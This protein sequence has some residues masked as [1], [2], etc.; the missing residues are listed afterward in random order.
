MVSGETKQE[1][2][3]SIFTAYHE[4]KQTAE[5]KEKTAAQK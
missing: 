4:V 2:P 5:R 1:K 3:G